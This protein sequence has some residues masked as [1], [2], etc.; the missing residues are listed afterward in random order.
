MH[1][2][3]DQLAVC[4]VDVILTA[5]EYDKDIETPAEPA[6]P[7]ENGLQRATTQP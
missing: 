5:A 2:A 1:Q 7:C 3:L 6:L 4:E